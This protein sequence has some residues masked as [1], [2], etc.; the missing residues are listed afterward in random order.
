MTTEDHKPANRGFVVALWGNVV[1]VGF[2]ESVPAIYS[3]LHACDD[4]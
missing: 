4:A 1:D 3:A 2:D